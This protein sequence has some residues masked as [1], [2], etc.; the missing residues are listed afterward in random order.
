MGIP[1]HSGPRLGGS[2]RGLLARSP[3]ESSCPPVPSASLGAARP[4]Q[5]T[6]CS[7]QV[8]HLLS[9]RH[10][11]WLL[12]WHLPLSRVW[13][14]QATEL[15]LTA[16]G[17]PAGLRDCGRGRKLACGFSLAPTRAAASRRCPSF[18]STFVWSHQCCRL[19]SW[20]PQPPGRTT[21]TRVG[22]EAAQRAAGRPGRT[23]SVPQR[24]PGSLCWSERHCGCRRGDRRA[25]EVLRRR[26]LGKKCF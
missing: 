13:D 12:A 5:E 25:C 20:E 26:D 4:V 18:S 14:F 6:T 3:P 7:G 15:A 17:A 19:S 24:A 11:C 2:H 9:G 16:R 22:A 1:G 8:P 10:S 21:G 23:P